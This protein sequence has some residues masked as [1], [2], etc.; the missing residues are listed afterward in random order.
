MSFGESEERRGMTSQKT[1]LAD[2]Q[3]G[4]GQKDSALEKKE[5]EK[6]YRGITVR[7]VIFTIRCR[8]SLVNGEGEVEDSTLKPSA[9]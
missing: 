5:E 2:G 7:Q 9:I 1:V 3:E 6:G 8:K 4:L